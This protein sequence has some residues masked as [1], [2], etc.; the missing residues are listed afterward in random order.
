ADLS[1]F[2][3][4]LAAWGATRDKLAFLDPPPRPALT[5]AQ[6]LLVALGAVDADGRITEDGRKLR[7]LPLPPR[8][9]RMVV[10]AAEEDAALPAA[11]IAALI[12]GTGLGGGAGGVVPSSRGF[13]PR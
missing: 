4:D 13:P 8:L 6:T 10:D 11:E 1:G 7:R 5:E 2:A 12:G 3:L 9:A